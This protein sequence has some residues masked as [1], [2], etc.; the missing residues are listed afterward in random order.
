MK[1]DGVSGE[2][3]EDETNNFVIYHILITDN[4]LFSLFLCSLQIQIIVDGTKARNRPALPSILQ[5]HLKSD[6][7]FSYTW[8]ADSVLTLPLHLLISR[9]AV[10]YLSYLH[11]LKVDFYVSIK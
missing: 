3:L 1:Y 6:S 4:I 11:R 10:K 9:K 2:G 7:M 8:Y 5:N